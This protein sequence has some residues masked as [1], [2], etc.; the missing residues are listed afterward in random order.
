LIVRITIEWIIVIRIIPIIP[1]SVI[2]SVKI[3]IESPMSTQRYLFD[4]LKQYL[5]FK[6]VSGLKDYRSSSR[7]N[8]L[9]NFGA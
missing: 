9:Y 2:I 6:S 5:Y 4:K 3:I 1:I 8:N 7:S